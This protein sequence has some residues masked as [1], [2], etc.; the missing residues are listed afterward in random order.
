M[1]GFLKIHAPNISPTGSSLTGFSP[2]IRRLRFTKRFSFAAG[3]TIS[4]A[5]KGPATGTTRIAERFMTSEID[6]ILENF[7]LLEDWEDRYRYVIELGRTLPEMPEEEHTDANKVRGCVSQVW[8][9]R[10]VEASPGGEPVIS[11]RGDSDAHIVRGLVAIV[12][13]LFSGRTAREILSTDVD[14]VFSRIGLREHL[15]PQR[16]NGLNAMV[17]KIRSDARAALAAA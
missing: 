11:Y 12:L 13:A 7:E 15:T 6:D 14:A 3:R 2:E 17:E 8:L 9:V 5:A 4:G 10:T 1:A 16:S